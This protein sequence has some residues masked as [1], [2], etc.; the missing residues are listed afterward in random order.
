MVRPAVV[1]SAAPEGA[2]VASDRTGPTGHDRGGGLTVLERLGHTLL[3]DLDGLTDRLVDAIGAS[4]PEYVDHPGVPDDELRDSI[5]RNLDRA[6]RQ[7][8][9][10]LP[11]DGGPDDPAR[12]TGIRRAQQGVPLEVVLRSY[13]L[14]GRVIWDA[15]VDAGRRLEDLDPQELMEAATRVWRLIDEH[16][17]AVSEGYRLEESRLRR[18]DLRQRQLTLDAL[19]E[20]RGS[21]PGF[22]REAARTLGLPLDVPLVC[23]V[24][25]ID[26]PGADP[27]RAPQE[28][29]SAAGY[30]AVW[31][32]R[33]GAE[34]GLV[35]VAD[36]DPAALVGV[37]DARADGRVGISPPV[38][39]LAEVSTAYR[40]AEVSA[41]TLSP[42]HPAVAFLD[43]R[44]PEALLA[45]SP[46]IVPRLRARTV[47]AL[48]DLAPDD[49]RALIATVAAVLANDG[50]PTRAAEQLFCHRNTVAYRLQ[51]VHELTGRG[52]SD[53]RD[54]LLW[55]LALATEP[56][57][58][59]GPCGPRVEG[60]PPSN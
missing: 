54:K 29:C 52:I 32:V 2:T 46:E 42:E 22:A 14:G 13:R 28:A 11:S 45:N 34:V 41:F 51:R 59:A 30:P 56:C 24:A 35:A 26:A 50:S 10:E 40:L 7:L 4:E 12:L 18:R 6:V 57:D 47:A 27:L 20:G 3:G 38:D 21:D 15:L 44:L 25:L 19:I 36:R 48:A 31:Q 43:D 1:G 16:S 37:L 55:T 9:E 17:S 5:R 53:P 60:Q 58:P 23:V 49:R 33:S 39:S 8:I